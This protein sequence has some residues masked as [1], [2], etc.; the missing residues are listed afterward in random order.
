MSWFEDCPNQKIHEKEKEA[1]LKQ[2]I[3][4]NEM[5]KMSQKIQ[6]NKPLDYGLKLMHE[7]R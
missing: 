7:V 1:K 5:W 2:Y 3:N 4:V 6:T